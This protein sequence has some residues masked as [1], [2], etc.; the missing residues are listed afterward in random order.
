MFTAWIRFSA[1]LAKRANPTATTP[2][3]TVKHRDAAT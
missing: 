2:Q 3:A 1:R